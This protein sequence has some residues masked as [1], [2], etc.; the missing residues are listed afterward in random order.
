MSDSRTVEILSRYKGGIPNIGKGPGTQGGLSEESPKYP[1]MHRRQGTLPGDIGWNH[2]NNEHKWANQTENTDLSAVADKRHCRSNGMA[3]QETHLTVK[4][5]FMKLPG[6]HIG[7]MLLKQSTGNAAG[8][9]SRAAS[10][11]NGV[12]RSSTRST[13]PAS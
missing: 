1:S 12:G 9:G 8:P 11:T 4:H 6:K 10:V 3:L 2:S 13:T 5:S 7:D